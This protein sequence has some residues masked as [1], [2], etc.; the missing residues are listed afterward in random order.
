MENPELLQSIEELNEKSKTEKEET[1]K[2]VKPDIVEPSKPAATVFVA[3]NKQVETRLP[4]GK[5]RITPMLLTPAPAPSK[6]F[7]I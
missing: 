3:A 4:S 2:P 1:P 7:F 6:Y 5:R